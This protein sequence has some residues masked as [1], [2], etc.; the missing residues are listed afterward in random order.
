[1]EILRI[2]RADQYEID[3]ERFFK[4]VDASSF[5]HEMRD[6]NRDLTKL[7]LCELK[8]L[9]MLLKIAKNQRKQILLDLIR[10]RII[11]E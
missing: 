8:N 4:V 2:P 3:G 7:S 5:T 9:A 6:L 11:F 1:M 10:P